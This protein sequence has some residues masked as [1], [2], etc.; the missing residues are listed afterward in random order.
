MSNINK[1]KFIFGFVVI[2]FYS[3]LFYGLCS[4]ADYLR[5]I[6]RNEIDLIDKEAEFIDSSIGK[7]VFIDGDSLTIVNWNGW[8]QNFTLS[9]GVKINRE[10]I[11]KLK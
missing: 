9:S 6:N 10:L 8:T 3:F 7:K 5:E 2:V 4:I 11:E 1:F